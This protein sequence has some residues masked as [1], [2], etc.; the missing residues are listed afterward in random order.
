MPIYVASKENAT[1]PRI[2]ADMS[3]VVTDWYLWSNGG[4]GAKRGGGEGGWL[5]CRMDRNRKERVQRA[6]AE[7]MQE[8][9]MS[10]NAVHDRHPSLSLYAT[11]ASAAA[12]ISFSLFLL[13]LQ[14]LPTQL[15]N[16]FCL[17]FHTF[18]NGLIVKQLPQMFKGGK[19]QLHSSSR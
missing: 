8:K 18:C 15:C 11:T 1:R 13:F 14:A 10:D 7:Y 9:N 12:L 19:W 17:P 4:E 5:G 3:A 16:F 6:E 2:S